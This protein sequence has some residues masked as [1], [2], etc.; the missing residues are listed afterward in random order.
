MHYKSMLQILAAYGPSAQ[1]STKE[2]S[3]KLSKFLAKRRDFDNDHFF[4]TR[5]FSTK[6]VSGDLDRLYRMGFLNRKRARRVLFS[7][8]PLGRLR[9]FMYVYR[10]SAQGW[11]YIDYMRKP[12]RGKRPTVEDVTLGLI[13]DDMH[14]MLPHPIAEFLEEGLISKNYQ[15]SGRHNR[16][17]NKKYNELSVALQLCRN[18]LRRKEEEIEKLMKMLSGQT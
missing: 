9:G 16:F 2:L 4:Y 8:K 5:Q 17:P 7:E 11:Q 1:F 12:E 15:D 6:R 3:D 10:V 18:E 14:R 13:A